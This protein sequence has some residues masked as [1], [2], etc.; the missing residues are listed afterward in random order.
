VDQVDGV[1]LERT[2]PGKQVEGCKGSLVLQCSTV[3]VGRGE[4]PRNSNS[5][6]PCGQLDNPLVGQRGEGD[7]VAVRITDTHPE[8]TLAG[9]S[10]PSTLV[11]EKPASILHYTYLLKTVARG[12]WD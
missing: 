5:W 4:E 7:V 12:C 3:A 2:T 8:T 9:Q 1:E 11:V 6:N 10:D